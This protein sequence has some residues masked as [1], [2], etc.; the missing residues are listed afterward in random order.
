M[1]YPGI[2]DKG[3]P[4]IPVGI[5]TDPEGKIYVNAES[6][7]ILSGIAPPERATQSMLSVKKLL[8]SDYGR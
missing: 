3:D 8:M 5:H 6:W 4:F 1:V 7:L 2:F